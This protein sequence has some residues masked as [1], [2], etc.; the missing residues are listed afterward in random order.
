MARLSDPV[1][2]LKGVGPARAKQ[3]ENLCIRTL[4]DLICH[5]PRGYE[6]SEEH[7]SE[8]QSPR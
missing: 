1:T 4:G 6:R 3:L 5:F 7:T 2:L 8:L